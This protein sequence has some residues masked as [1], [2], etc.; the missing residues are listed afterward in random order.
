MNSMNCV[1]FEKL[2]FFEV[3][4]PSNLN[5]KYL[6]SKSQPRKTASTIK[7][8]IL[9]LVFPFCALLDEFSRVQVN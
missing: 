6:K 4:S 5:P 3:T 8:S 7:I 9:E 1:V 2:Y